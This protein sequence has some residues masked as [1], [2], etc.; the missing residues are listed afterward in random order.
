MGAASSSVTTPVTTPVTLSPQLVRSRGSVSETLN[1]GSSHGRVPPGVPREIPGYI[2]S[3]RGVL[4]TAGAFPIPLSVGTA[5]ATARSEAVASLDR[6]RGG[7]WPAPSSAPLDP[8]YSKTEPRPETPPLSAHEIQAIVDG[9]LERAEREFEK[10]QQKA[11][12]SA[13]AVR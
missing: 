11:R 9:K 2:E 7:G 12:N 6:S 3:R 4:M 10:A 5:L 8:S 13:R 1:E